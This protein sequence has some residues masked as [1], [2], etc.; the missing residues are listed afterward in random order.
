[1]GTKH[2]WTNSDGLRRYG[3]PRTP[4]GNNLTAEKAIDKEITPSA[5]VSGGGNEDLIVALGDSITWRS[6]ITAAGTQMMASTSFLGWAQ[7]IMSGRFRILNLGISGNTTAQMLARYATDVTPTRARWLHLLAGGNDVSALTS[8]AEVAQTIS[9]LS[10]LVALAQSEGR[11]VV[12]GTIYPFGV[13]A[14]AIRRAAIAQINQWV[15]QQA[16]R[17]I[18]VDYYAAMVDAAGVIRSGAL[19]ADAIHPSTF[20]ASLMGRALS[21]V[22]AGQL[23]LRDEVL[24][25]SQ[26][27]ADNGLSN[28]QMVG[29]HASGTSSFTASAGMT[30]TGPRG[31]TWRRGTG[32]AMAATVSKQART[33]GIISA[34]YARAVVTTSGADG[35]SIVLERLVNLRLWS[36][37]GTAN[38]IRRFYVPATGCQY[39][40]LTDGTFAVESDPTATWP[41]DIG[42]TFTSGTATLMCVPPIQP[43][44]VV[45]A[46]VECTIS[47][48]ATG[49]VQPALHFLLR[50]SGGT[51][52][53]TAYGQY[54]DSTH[55]TMPAAAEAGAGLVIRTP[56]IAIG[57]LLD[58]STVTA[59]AGPSFGVQ[60]YLSVRGSATATVDW[61]RATIRVR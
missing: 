52:R 27:D 24:S 33:G 61:G 26:L 4:E 39:D 51:S 40:V 32:A 44:S 55:E 59:S 42:A 35:D 43:G 29:N 7:S 57:S 49:T 47:S 13:H 5:P 18:V 25:S 53:Y 10:Q 31:W 22:L 14:T 19:I 41:T 6:N 60:C 46:A 54:W 16:P 21:L 38:V 36:S 48:I 56:E 34:D 17:C 28:G 3:G 15:R 8:A 12:L 30:G 20:G 2:S 58:L 23:P 11:T 50:D 1:M 45:S 9:N 37:G